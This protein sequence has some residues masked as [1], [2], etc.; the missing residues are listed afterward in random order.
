MRHRESVALASILLS[1]LLI[2]GVNACSPQAVVRDTPGSCRDG[3][4][5]YDLADSGAAG[6]GSV[7]FPSRHG[8]QLRVST[9]PVFVIKKQHVEKAVITHHELE[10]GDNRTLG[11]T[12]EVFGL[13]LILTPAAAK[14]L[15]PALTDRSSVL[16]LAVCRG[17]AV[18]FAGV[19]EPLPGI[20]YIELASLAE[21]RRVAAAVADRVVEEP[22][23]RVVATPVPQLEE[24]GAQPRR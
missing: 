12:V 22:R 20:V 5:L 6:N 8:E 15:S 23:H 13:T 4:V 24:G 16:F 11:R 21:A 2:L 9:P 19:S 14:E 7:V 1:Y 18:A 17:Q 3:V 10:A